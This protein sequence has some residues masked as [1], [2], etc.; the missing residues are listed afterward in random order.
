MQEKLI[1]NITKVAIERRILSFCV[2]L[3]ILVGGVL[4]Y[5]RLGVL[6]DPTFTV[7]TAL[8]ITSYP[9][10]TAMEVEQEVTER[11]SLEIQQLPQLRYL[12]SENRAGLSLIT[13]DIEEKYL[14]SEMP[15]IWDELRKKVSK[16]RSK[17]PPG[18]GEPLVLDTDF[19]EVYGHLLSLSAGAGY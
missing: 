13:V 12:K 11:L 3:L 10:A 19:G 8:V 5:Y 15:Q 16:G 2:I 14:S 4:S 1:S 7:K 18:V 17:L 9:G 6:E